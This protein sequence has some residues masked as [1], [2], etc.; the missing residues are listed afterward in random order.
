MISIKKTS[1]ESKDA[2]GVSHLHVDVRQIDA[3]GLKHL[4]GVGININLLQNDDSQ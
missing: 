3:K 4:L 2:C 1:A